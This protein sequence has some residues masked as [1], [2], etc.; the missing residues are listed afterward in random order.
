MSH[1]A[2]SEPAVRDHS[3]RVSNVRWELVTAGLSA[4]MLAE[5][6]AYRS[7]PLRF[8]ATRLQIGGRRDRAKALASGRNDAQGERSGRSVDVRIQDGLSKS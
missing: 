4:E 7:L 1:E 2:S 8:S 3:R 6:A 5:P